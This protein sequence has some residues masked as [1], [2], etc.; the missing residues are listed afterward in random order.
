M[1]GLCALVEVAIADDA[2]KGTQLLRL[3]G[4]IHGA[5]GPLPVTEHAESLEILALLRHLL[6]SE[7]AASGS[8]SIDVEFAAGASDFLLDRMLDRQSV[9]V[10]P[11]DVR[12]IVSIERARFDDDVLEDF[13]QCVPDMNRAV[14]VRRPIVQHEARPTLRDAA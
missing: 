12:R 3:V 2:P 4:G 5:V 8:K 9:A 14:G 11:G 7:S 10:P 6:L 1:D 13:I